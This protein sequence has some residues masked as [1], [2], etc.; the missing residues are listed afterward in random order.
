MMKKVKK[1]L[2]KE[3]KVM[4]NTIMGWELFRPNQRAALAVPLI[5]I[6]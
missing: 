1:V 2:E 3:N 5:A 6:S 4:Y